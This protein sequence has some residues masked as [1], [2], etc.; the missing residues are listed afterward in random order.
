MT[1][2]S[3]KAVRVLAYN[4]MEIMA[5]SVTTMKAQ[6]EMVSR[7]FKSMTPAVVA[8]MIKRGSNPHDMTMGE[9]KQK[10]H[11]IKA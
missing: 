8:E 6:T 10:S 2:S 11:E 7:T 5:E 3:Q 9:L 4:E 1:E